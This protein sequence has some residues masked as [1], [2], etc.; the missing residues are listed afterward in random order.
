MAKVLFNT[1]KDVQR[2]QF[3][4]DMWSKEPSMTKFLFDTQENMMK[5]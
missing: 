4:Q 2:Y 1:Q 5:Y 3:T